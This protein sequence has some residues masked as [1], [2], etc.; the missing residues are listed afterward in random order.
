MRRV[1][2][3]AGTLA[4]AGIVLAFTAHAGDRTVRSDGRAVRL[5]AP[6]RIAPAPSDGALERLPPSTPPEKPRRIARNVVDERIRPLALP[7]AE[8]AGRLAAGGFVIT[9]AGI[10]PTPEDRLCA[11]PTGAPWPCGRLAR[12]AFRAYLRGRTLKCRIPAEPAATGEPVVT[13]CT[14]A[15]ADVAEWLAGQGWAMAEGERYAA[16][17]MAAR[18]AQRGLWSAGDGLFRPLLKAGP[19]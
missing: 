1:A 8:A 6:D 19:R 2:A 18:A 17:D 4:L 7:V 5:I 3:M 13:E 16:L 9:L 10:V 15:G 11:A 12:T 14:I